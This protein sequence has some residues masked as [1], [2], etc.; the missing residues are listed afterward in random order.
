MLD[1]RHAFLALSATAL[2][3]AIGL[4]RHIPVD[5]FPSEYDQ[6]MIILEAPTDFGLEQT[7]EVVLGIERALECIWSSAESRSLRHC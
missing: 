3:F 2:Y 1:H 5:L 6:V 7:N 4:A